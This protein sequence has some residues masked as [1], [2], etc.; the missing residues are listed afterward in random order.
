MRNW[1]EQC[2][3][4]HWCLPYLVPTAPFSPKCCFEG[5]AWEASLCSIQ[6]LRMCSSQAGRAEGN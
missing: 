5:T 2:A 6:I 4:A 1:V 3:E